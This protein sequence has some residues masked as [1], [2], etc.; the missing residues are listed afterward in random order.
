MS[1]RVVM[2]EYERAYESKRQGN[3]MIRSEGRG[4]V[5]L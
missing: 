2:L 1:V 5:T 3:G 4:G